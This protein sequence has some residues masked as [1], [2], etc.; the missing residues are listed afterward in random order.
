MPAASGFFQKSLA[1][2]QRV[3]QA[4]LPAVEY[5]YR[6]KCGLLFLERES[7]ALRAFGFDGR[8]DACATRAAALICDHAKQPAISPPTAHRLRAHIIFGG[9]DTITVNKFSARPADRLH[10]YARLSGG[11]H[12]SS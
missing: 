3:A 7:A 11:L 8:Q 10:N 5:F 12:K 9:D 1:W 4:S 2:V 6:A